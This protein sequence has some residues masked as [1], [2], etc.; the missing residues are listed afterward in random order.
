[1][2]SWQEER[3]ASRRATKRPVGKLKDQLDQG[4]R[5][6]VRNKSSPHRDEIYSWEPVLGHPGHLLKLA[7]AA[8]PPAD[9]DLNPTEFLPRTRRGTKYDRVMTEEL[10]TNRVDLEYEQIPRL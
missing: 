10:A 2:S 9:V 7:P 3:S 6:Q 4:Q 8:W 1:M 5:I